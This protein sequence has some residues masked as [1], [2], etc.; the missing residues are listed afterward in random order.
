MRDERDV[1]DGERD[2]NMGQNALPEYICQCGCLVLVCL[3]TKRYS[4]SKTRT[5]AEHGSDRTN[6]VGRYKRKSGQT[7]S[8]KR[9]MKT[10][11]WHY[12]NNNT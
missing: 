5:A 11:E 7:K 10:K 6:T 1:R 9:E 4:E 3:L 8:S 12:P 2:D